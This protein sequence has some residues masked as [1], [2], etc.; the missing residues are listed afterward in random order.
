M[1]KLDPVKHEEKRRDILEAAGRCFVRKGFRGTTV[2]DIC[3]EAKISAG[4]LY[5]YF[6]SKE[7]IISAIAEARLEQAN[8]R[9]SRTT[10]EHNALGAILSEIDWTNSMSGA[11][12]LVARFEI[13]AEA[14]RNPAMAEILQKHNRGMCRL[15]GGL[16]R[17]GQACG[18]IDPEL[19]PELVANVL[20][21]VLD[22]FKTVSIRDPETD[23]KK[24]FHLLKVLI[25]RFLAPPSATP[26][27]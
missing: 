22:G 18:Q 5:H 9:F 11:S 2:S 12:G 14:G 16:L 24:S 20:L 21:S 15:L 17:K 26:D 13:L 19:D 7:A 23:L 6:P 8:E 4:H 27:T 25:T 3:S 10:E 1:R